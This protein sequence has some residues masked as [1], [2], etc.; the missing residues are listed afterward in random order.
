MFLHCAIF[1]NYIYCQNTFDCCFSQILLIRVTISVLLV[2][3]LWVL[4]ITYWNYIGFG[5][6]NMLSFEPARVMD[7]F[8]NAFNCGS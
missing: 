4:F 8:Q 6:E 1:L 7:T 3:V 5:I 2:V